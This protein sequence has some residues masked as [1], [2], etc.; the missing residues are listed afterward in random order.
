MTSSTFKDCNQ[1]TIHNT[2]FLGLYNSTENL[3]KRLVPELKILTVLL[4]RI[5]KSIISNDQ[6]HCN[7]HFCWLRKLVSPSAEI[8]CNGQV[9]YNGNGEFGNCTSTSDKL[10]LSGYEILFRKMSIITEHNV[11]RKVYRDL[12]FY[13]SASTPG[14]IALLFEYFKTFKIY[15]VDFVNGTRII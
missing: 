12:R 11:L 6:P 4:D 13:Y 15:S 3:P 7:G 9:Y 1:F 5:T 14:K 10:G 8:Y 2:T